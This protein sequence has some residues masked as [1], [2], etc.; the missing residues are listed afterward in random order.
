MSPDCIKRLTQAAGRELSEAEVHSIF[1]RVHKAALDIKAGR[2]ELQDI[3]LGKPLK[4][5]ESDI[6]TKGGSAE[7]IVQQSALRAARE[8]QHEADVS[9][10]QANLQVARLGARQS[11]VAKLQ[12]TGLG[13]LDAVERT[14]ARD[15]TGRT[16]VESLEQK[17]AG[18][19]AYFGRKLIDTWNSLGSDFVGF[20]Q[21]RAKLIN[22]IRELRGEDAHDPLAKKG[23]KAFHDTAEEAR[24][25]F[26]ENGGDVGRL[27]DWGM[28]Q[29]HSQEKV[30]AVGKDKW[31]DQTLPLL[32][33]SKYADE[34]GQRW[35]EA[36]LREFLGKA[37]N[38]IATNGHA[39]IEP[40][41]FTGIGKTANR[42]A[43]SRQIH[44][45]DAESVVNYWE[46]FGEKTAVEILHGHVDTMAKDIAFVEHFGPN[47][48]LTYQTLLDSAL[49]AAT[50][51][52][53]VK[54]PNLE[55]RAIK[56]DELYNY[57]AGKVKPTYNKTL[58]AVADGIAHLNTA[59]KLGGAVLASLFGDKPMMEA[60]SHMNDLP[61][62]GRWRTELALLNPANTEDRAL[63]QRQGLMLEGIRSGLQ[64][65]YE[66]LGQTSTTGRMAN[67][68]M[69][70]TGMQAI[71][72]I[73][74]G[75]FGLSLMDAI[76][77]EL[78]KG[79]EFDKLHESD[80][81]TLR[82]YG[83]TKED[84]AIWKLAK[85][86]EIA[87]NKNVLTPE[88]ISRI[89]DADIAK[90]VGGHV[91]KAQE[92]IGGHI[93]ELL[94]RNSVEDERLAKR[95]TSIKEY[96]AK[97]A[98]RLNRYMTSKDEQVRQ[99]A[100]L[101]HAR[102][103]LL[104]ARVER[105]E[106]QADIEAYLLQQKSR[107]QSTD[108]AVDLLM[109]RNTENILTK[110]DRQGDAASRQRG[111]IGER[112][113]EK[114]GSA[115]RRVTEMEGKIRE[116][117]R[118][119]TGDI[120]AKYEELSG[121]V[122]DRMEEADAWYKESQSRVDRRNAVIDR[123]LGEA[124][125]AE[126]ETANTM[127]RGAIVKL[128]GA[129]N[130]ESDFAIVTPGWRERASFYGDLQRGTIKGEISRSVLQFKAFPWAFF[131]R[132]MDAVANMEG[133]TS[134]AAMT[135]YLIVTTTLAGAMLMQTR[136]MLTGKDP[137]KMTDENWYKF[138]GAAFLQGGALGIYGDFLYGVNQT[139]YGSGPLETMAGPTLGPLL[140]M[141]VVQPLNA[142]KSHMDGKESHF[143]AHELQTA[144][145]FSPAA[146]IW[147]TKAALDHL[148]WQRVLEMLSP[149]YLATIRDS[150]RKQF[151]QDW[152][153]RPGEALPERAPDLKGALQR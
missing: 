149:G 51:A 23:A 7:T 141:G 127:R 124:S 78:S 108:M 101:L 20:F 117:E 143:L 68:V 129:V 131:V 151:S 109:G 5:L 97:V 88:S 6:A 31:I 14:L 40:G 137:R 48:A 152:W 115:D 140:D 12:G 73:R 50:L 71:N 38:T 11:D 134:K 118:I 21:D 49:K 66:G 114:R 72:E 39:N 22:L 18:Y 2:A 153:W 142:I 144:K 126:N 102:Q 13:P 104:K 9:E 37:W 47:P 128:L 93:A 46:S 130:T 55:G 76:G 10:R 8:L 135:A 74:K 91:Q 103:D 111:G 139:R 106:V 35:S 26:N 116:L 105:A 89:S 34:L 80:I 16:N 147:Y 1:E 113:G 123:L 43:E 95:M 61:A 87:G 120:K 63:I 25:V 15:Y 52:N 107:N 75:S 59:G 58:R 99:A 148:I 29:H 24:K 41:K 94:L 19:N 70:I 30:A 121:L 145:G 45:K 3:K 82:N 67:A 64:R 54:T 112:L 27:D 77:T 62:L 90:A 28:P 98:E 33:K 36:Q 125:N 53:P 83:I 119:A 57:S 42:H 69:R 150:S 138:W 84:W 17:S 60:V 136:D 32:D 100:E 110:S 65:F 96:E 85:P 44:F 146:N 81:R 122:Q 79:V 132:S 56:L 4:G 86:E 133:A 92:A